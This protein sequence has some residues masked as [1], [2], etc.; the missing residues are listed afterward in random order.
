MSHT[1]SN[2]KQY[3]A[4]KLEK[5]VKVTVTIAVQSRSSVLIND[6]KLQKC[7]AGPEQFTVCIVFVQQQ[8]VYLPPPTQPNHSLLIKTHTPQYDM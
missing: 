8:Q 4:C 5:C 3:L 2:S 6:K 1:I 7:C